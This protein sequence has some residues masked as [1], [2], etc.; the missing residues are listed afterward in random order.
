MYNE[1]DYISNLF[2][3]NEHLLEEKP[4]RRA[5]AK[6]EEKLDQ[7]KVRSTRRIYRYISTAAAVIAIVA[8]VSAIALFKNGNSLVA[9]NQ[10]VTVEN[11]QQKE[12]AMTKAG[13]DWRKE[14]A[15]ETLEETEQTAVAEK[16]DRIA[17]KSSQ[18]ERQPI[19]TDN[20]SYDKKQEQVSPSTQPNFTPKAKTKSGSTPFATP[21]RP[22][23]PEIQVESANA[24]REVIGEKIKRHLPPAPASN[25][26][27]D[28]DYEAIKRKAEREAK[29]AKN[30]A[31]KKEYQT[32]RPKSDKTNTKEITKIT[33]ADFQWLT[34]AWSNTT[35]D[36]VSYE[37]WTKTDK[38]TLKAKGYLI[39]NGDTTFVESMQIKKIKNKIY[40]VSNFGTDKSS[41][42]F[43]LTNYHNGVATFENKKSKSPTKVVITK[44]ENN[45][46]TITFQEAITPKL[47][48]R[49]NIENARATRNMSRAF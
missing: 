46:F 49:N 30:H 28:T 43:E 11:Q 44:N 10:T 35:P 9:D 27:D 5:W 37:K 29:I 1:E 42:K 6:L 48:Y 47:Q 17:K 32:T 15:P 8:M 7:D 23:S 4:S 31:T 20:A 36:G 26:S 18:T 39:Q 19:I 13:S 24:S 45:S 41:T 21:T 14:Y 38:N 3:D 12:L 22:S 34:G 40:Y 25:M 16:G 2:K 33:I